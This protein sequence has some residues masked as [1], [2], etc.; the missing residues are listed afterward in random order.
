L[1]FITFDGS[2]LLDAILDGEIMVT[3]ER[4]A[5][6]CEAIE[7]LESGSFDAVPAVAVNGAIDDL[8]EELIEATMDLA[9]ALVAR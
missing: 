2:T 4:V 9:L 6:L 7:L 5:L 1:S 8:Y 3:N